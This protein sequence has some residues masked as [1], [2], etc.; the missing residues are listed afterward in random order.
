MFQKIILEFFIV[1]QLFPAVFLIL[2]IMFSCVTLT[3]LSCKTPE[4]GIMYPNQC[5]T[6]DQGV[7]YPKRDT[8]MVCPH[9]GLN[10][11]DFSQEL[12]KV[13]GEFCNAAVPWCRP[14]S[15]PFTNRTS[16]VFHFH[17]ECFLRSLNF[18]KARCLEAVHSCPA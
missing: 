7:M 1:M 17:A 3:I 13:N 6:P 10:I 11:F 16:G 15:T 4:P 9:I 12:S 5:K 8:S 18:L 2:T 14:L